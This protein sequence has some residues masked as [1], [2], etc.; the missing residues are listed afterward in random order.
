MV[1]INGTLMAQILNFAILVFILAKFA[2]RPVMRVLEERQQKIADNID[3]AE[4]ER[5]E[6]Q[7]LKLEYQQKLADARA[8]AQAIVEKAEKLAIENKEEILKEARLESAR[9]LQTVQAE[10][11]RERELA[12]AQLRGEV[13][14]LSMAAAGKI[15]EKNIDDEANAALVSSFIEKLDTQKTGG[16]PC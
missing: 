13:I 7:Q 14:A 2:Y 15:I 8:Q 16:L 4:R 6:A 12:L 3:A 11:A 5:Q 1:E 10:V 9:I